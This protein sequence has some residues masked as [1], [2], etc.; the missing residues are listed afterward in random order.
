MDLNSITLDDIDAEIA[1][2]QAAANATVGSEAKGVFGQFVKGAEDTAGFLYSDL[3]RKMS[4]YLGM[5]IDYHDKTPYQWGQGAQEIKDLAKNLGEYDPNAISPPQTEVG[6]SL[7][8]VANYIGGNLVVPGGGALANIASGAVMGAGAEGAKRLGLP[9]TVGAIAAPLGTG[10]M[11]RLAIAKAPL[12]EGE[13]VVAKS[14]TNL[15][16][17]GI[18]SAIDE[19]SAAKEAGVV[20]NITD[21]Q[22]IAPEMQS[23]QKDLLSAPLTRDEYANALNEQIGT[24]ENAI[25]AATSGPSVY[26]AGDAL[27]EKGSNLLGGLTKERKE[28]GDAMYSAF[29]NSPGE[30]KT[31]QIEKIFETEPIAQ[32]ASNKVLNEQTLIPTLTD[33]GKVELAPPSPYDPNVLE[34]TLAQIKYE[35]NAK[36]GGNTSAATREDEVYKKLVSAIDDATSGAYSKAQSTYESLS[37][38][39]EELQSSGLGKLANKQG[40]TATKFL[41]GLSP[42]EI[43]AVAQKAPEEVRQAAQAHASSLFEKGITPTAIKN[44]LAPDMQ[45]KLKAALGEDTVSSINDVLSR[46]EHLVRKEYKTLPENN[47]GTRLQSVGRMMYGLAKSTYNPFYGVPTFLGGAVNFVRGPTGLTASQAKSL[48]PGMLGSEAGSQVLTNLLKNRAANEALSS[49][50]KQAL[51]SGARGG[52]VANMVN[53]LD[54][55]KVTLQD[56]DAEIARRQIAD[57]TSST[58]DVVNKVVQAE[59][60]GNPNAV[61]PK[62]AKGLMQLMDKTGQDL[63]NKSGVSYQPFNA[64]QNLELGTNYLQEQLNKFG[65]LKLALSAY[66]AGPTRVASLVKRYGNNYEAIKNKLPAETRSYVAK[67]TNNG[68]IG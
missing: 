34:Q 35:K 26:N 61:S 42:E 12:T 36:Y 13:K 28:A 9:E 15:P 8:T 20:K 38:P 1:R 25:K 55:S 59:S 11:R 50:N 56:I 27:A 21:A 45:A 47:T 60:S 17:E 44:Y 5:G 68:G 33:E 37:K 22:T 6:K 43:Q 48:L 31:P 58:P 18:Q 7:G 24:A 2:R 57:K 16:D 39:I 62:G 41:M 51:L 66:N 10:L 53:S 40:R 52:V 46:N 64:K 54:S 67:I 63:A 49:V 14:L 65:D 3:P 32:K 19:L 30:I 4:E 23:V 29:R